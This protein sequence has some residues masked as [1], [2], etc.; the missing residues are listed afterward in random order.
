M[1]FYGGRISPLPYCAILFRQCEICHGHFVVAAK[2]RRRYCSDGCSAQAIVAR[3][4]N[5][6][7]SIPAAMMHLERDRRSRA[8]RR[9][10]HEREYF[11][12]ERRDS[13]AFDPWKRPT[14]NSYRPGEL[15]FALLYGDRRTTFSRGDGN[16][17]GRGGGR[18]AIQVGGPNL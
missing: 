11:G 15:A 4:S 13:T 14:Q 5:K 3:Q 10:F 17:A 8:Q 9:A 7:S 6:I 1:G 12:E 2:V 18:H 16:G